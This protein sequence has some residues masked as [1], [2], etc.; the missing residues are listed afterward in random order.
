VPDLF[1]MELRA[2]RRDRAAR[3]GAELFLFERAFED[4]VERIDL[5]QRQFDRALLIGCPDPGWPKRL[6]A[7]RLDVVDP[8]PLFAA[9]AGGRTIVEDQWE[10]E[11]AAYD[12]IL[13]IGTLDTVNELPLALRL[14][15]AAMRPDALLIGAMSGGDTLPQLRAAMRSADSVAG[16]AAPHVH[17]RVEAAALAPL[18]EQ[19]GFVRPVVDV[20]RTQVSYRSLAA[21]VADLRAMGATNLLTARPHI[22]VTKSSLA[23]AA[24]HF[25]DS[26]N[27]ERTTEVFEILH[28]AAW[29]ASE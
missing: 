6:V 7:K 21:L 28:F 2:M 29:T 8:G 16:V 14:L 10:P 24:R 27:G 26:G 3:R 25:D 18:L 4:C 5:L 1:D 9:A 23:A 20:D 19:A 11:P 12:L 17:P 15:R 22:S 13:A